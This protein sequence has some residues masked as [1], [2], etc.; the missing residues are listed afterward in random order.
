MWIGVADG[1]QE[2]GETKGTG[3]LNVCSPV[4]WEKGSTYT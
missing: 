1:D 4:L 2:R 3:R